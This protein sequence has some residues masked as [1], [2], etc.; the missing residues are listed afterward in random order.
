MDGA[1]RGCTINLARRGTAPPAPRLVELVAVGEPSASY[2]V[3]C[4]RFVVEV[5]ERFDEETLLRLL[6]VVAAC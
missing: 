5:G 2:A 1:G 6:Q 4:G 3:R